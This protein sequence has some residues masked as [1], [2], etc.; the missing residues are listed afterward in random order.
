MDRR[1]FNTLLAGTAGMGFAGL[2]VS[3]ALADTYD[4]IMQRKK[5]MV[6][7]DMGNPPHGMMDAAF[8]PTGSD[9]ETAQL[10][11]KDMGVEFELVQ[12]A[13]PNR[14][15]YLLTN[16]CDMVISALSITDERKKVIDFSTPYA[17]LQCVVAAPK[18][19]E[20]KSYADLGG[21]GGISVTR[22]TV[23]DQELTR[24]TAAVK[25]VKI[26]RFEDDPTST[27][28][29]TSGQLK[30]YA[31]S[32][33]LLNQLR[34]DNPGLDL[35]TKFVMKGFPLG[36]AFRKNEPK[37]A[38]MLNAWVKTNLKNGKLVE[39]YKRYHGVT[40]SP[41]ELATKA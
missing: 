9:V 16:K 29:I 8:K 12:V 19:M 41:D 30:I 27:T 24:G 3:P 37:L 31:T 18:A 34:K 23:N 20:V 22:G 25:D 32:L 5:L 11:A 36:I 21:K 26:V 1:H 35:D 2:A 39:I 15:Q 40:L 10:L 13:T 28:A 17:E 38:E 33:P 7:I 6:A 14:V 4:T